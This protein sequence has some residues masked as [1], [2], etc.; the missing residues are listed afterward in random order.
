MICKPRS[1]PLCGAHMG[2]RLTLMT[3]GDIAKG[4]A[5]DVCLTA[6]QG[7]T[8]KSSTVVMITSACAAC[9]ANE[10]HMPYS[11]VANT[12]GT[13]ATAGLPISY[14]IVRSAAQRVRI[15]PGLALSMFTTAWQ[16]L[17][18]D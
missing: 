5:N 3:P 6:A 14:R 17:V 16:G 7:C 12:L 10:I 2:V 13:P 15:A 9:A 18:A 11:T 4:A 1:C 8:G